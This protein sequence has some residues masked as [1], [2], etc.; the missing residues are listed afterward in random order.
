MII[1]KK[2]WKTV[3]LPEET[4]DFTYYK[5]YTEEE[6]NILKKGRYPL[7]MTDR[8]FW[9]FEDNKLYM[10]RSW[11]GFCDYVV[12]FNIFNET[13]KVLVNN[14]QEQ[15]KEMPIYQHRIIVETSIDWWLKN[16]VEPCYNMIKEEN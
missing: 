6:M 14:N 10:H 5:K 12:E 3:E 16:H 13:H 1:N 8:W 9:Y 2:M 7:E 4:I 11:T 15:L